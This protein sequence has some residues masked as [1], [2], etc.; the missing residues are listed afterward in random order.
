MWQKKSDLNHAGRVYFMKQA[1][2]VLTAGTDRGVFRQATDGTW[3]ADPTFPQPTFDYVTD[4]W[5]GG[6]FEAW[7]KSDGIAFVMP[8]TGGGFVSDHFDP[9][10]GK[11]V[12]GLW[13]GQFTRISTDGSGDST[14]SGVDACYACTEVGLYGLCAGDRGGSFSA[15]L[16]GREMFGLNP[17]TTTVTLP[18]GGTATV[19]LKFYKIFQSLTVPPSTTVPVPIYILTSGGIFKVR[20]WKWCD[21]AASDSTDTSGGDSGD[22]PVNPTLDFDVEATGAVG[23]S[24]YCF[25]QSVYTG[26]DGNHPKDFVGSDKGVWRSFDY[27]VT[28]QRCERM[29]GNDVTVYDLQY[30]SGCILA[31]TDDGFWASSDDGDT[32]ARPGDPSV[33]ATFSS[34]VSSGIP[35]ASN[36]L[37]QTF[38]PAQS[39]TVVNKVSAYLS[40]EMPEGLSDAEA[41]AAQSNTVTAHLYSCDGSGAPSALLATSTDTLLASAAPFATFQSFDIAATLASSTASY[42]VVLKETSAAGAGGASVFQWHQSTLPDPYAGGGAY[43]SASGSASTWAASVG[44][45]FYFRVFFTAAVNPVF[46]QVQAGWDMGNGRGVLTTDTGGLTTDVKLAAVMVVDDSQS[47][48]WSDPMD[49]RLTAIPSFVDGLLGRTQAT[50]GGSPYCPSFAD[51]WLFGSSEIERTGGYSNSLAQVDLYGSALYARGLA[52]ALYDTCNI[53]ISGLNAQSI[54]DAVISPSDPSGTASRVALVVQYLQALGALRLTDVAAYWQGLPAPKSGWDGTAGDISN[55]ADVSEFVVAR[56]A[57]SFVPVALVFADGDDD[58]SGT[59]PMVALTANSAWG[60]V[61]APVHAFGLGRSHSEGGL[62]TITLATG[63]RQFDVAATSDWGPSLSSLQHGGENTL[64]TGTWARTFDFTDPVW[65]ESVHVEYA[66]PDFVSG[67]GN[68][69]ASC[70]VEAQWTTDRIHWTPWTTLTSGADYPLSDLILGLNLRV[71]MHTGWAD[72]APANPS[73]TA[74]YFTQVTPSRQYLVTPPQP[75]SGMLFE[76]L[77]SAAYDLPRT[78]RLSWGLVRG[79]STDFADFEAIRNGRKGALPNRQ[80]SLQF[81][82]VVNRDGLTLTTQ[83]NQSYQVIGTN[84]LPAT[85]TTDDQVDVLSGTR[86]IDPVAYSLDGAKGIVYFSAIQPANL[87]LTVNI[88]TPQRLY[89]STGEPCSTS[90]DKTYYLSNGRWASDAT[91]IVL[92]NGQIKRGGYWASPA[93]GT[94]TF[95]KERA[96]TDIVTVFIQDSPTYRVGVELLNYGT[97]APTL[98]NFGLYFTSQNN[99]PLLYSFYNTPTPQIV[100]NAVTLSPASPALNARMTVSYVFKSIDGNEEEGTLI[101]WYRIRGGVTQKLDGTSGTVDYSNRITERTVDLDAVG[102]LF[103]GGD[104]VYVVVSPSDGFSTGLPVQSNTVTLLGTHVP[105]VDTLVISAPSITESP[106]GSGIFYAAAG[107]TVTASYAW[108]SLDSAPDMSSVVWRLKDD[109]TTVYAV[110]TVIPA[111]KTAKGAVLSFTVTPYDGHTHG[112]SVTSGYITIQ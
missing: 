106:V 31:S 20:N 4:V 60:G 105:F 108:H 93:E 21:P 107:G 40:V 35:L 67:S 62:R 90:D 84:G 58:A 103:N 104:Q 73:V 42:A 7:G 22:A 91:A 97:T 18:S 92:I 64:F 32:W 79:D 76:Y 39:Q 61:G 50:L 82:P 102:G 46:T 100:G 1:D 74:F 36:F 87:T 75:A 89:T 110:G 94:I 27:G 85:W 25:C 86:I 57:Q 59:A 10:D 81:T 45:D 53:A 15:L 48:G 56:W 9:I 3:A 24:C 26:S 44:Q 38:V 96:S 37:A 83:D 99:A 112:T 70:L 65:V 109:I 98:D 33:C 71:T 78:A 66:I 28:W 16:T 19:P 34:S 63:G 11:R 69:A 88:T 30:L 6:T 54:I 101:D 68:V 8:Q 17:L 111:G 95:A 47:A 2:G 49:Y 5:N 41:M 13:H 29:G 43:S 12:Y 23:D 72:S 14:F 55:R 80:Q 52:S 51:F 77:L